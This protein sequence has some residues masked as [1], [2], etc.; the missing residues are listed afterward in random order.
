[1]FDNT[2]KFVLKKD[3]DDG[4]DSS[5]NKSTTSDIT[6]EQLAKAF[7]GKPVGGEAA[8]SKYQNQ[9]NKKQEAKK[10]NQ[11]ESSETK[12]RRAKWVKIGLF[13][14]VWLLLIG[15]AIWLAF[16]SRPKVEVVGDRE[17]EKEFEWTT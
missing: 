17:G 16:L 14:V 1:M 11:K 13:L 10:T 4:N 9:E 6:S 15:G 7:T 12:K 3:Q 8:G 2:Q 5:L